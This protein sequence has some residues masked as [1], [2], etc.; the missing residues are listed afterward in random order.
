[1]KRVKRKKI[2][3]LQQKIDYHT[4]RKNYSKEWLAGVYED[5]RNLKSNYDAT[6]LEIKNRKRDGAFKGDVVPILL[7]YRNGLKASLDE[8]KK[9]RVNLNNSA[10]VETRRRLL[11]EGRTTGSKKLKTKG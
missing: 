10:Y 6:C 7:G 5:Y 4:Q 8:T 2:F 11:A 9:P 3:T 1:M